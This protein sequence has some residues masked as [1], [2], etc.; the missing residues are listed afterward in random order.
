MKSYVVEP[1]NSHE[2][3]IYLEKGAVVWFP[4]VG[5]HRDKKY[6]PNPDIFDP[7]R[8]SDVN[9]DKI[10]PNT[11]M[12]FG[13]GPR[14]C[15]GLRFALLETKILFCRLLSKFSLVTTDKTHVE[16]KLSM[17]TISLQPENEFWVGLKARS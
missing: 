2:K 13:V 16:L 8:F 4:I 3:P 10:D 7:E 1:E 11:Y 17:A 5:I 6:Y 9:K 14:S 12:P 15:I